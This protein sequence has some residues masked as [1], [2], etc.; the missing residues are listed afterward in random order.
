M[1]GVSRFIALNGPISI[2]GLL[3]AP[4][5]VKGYFE[6]PPLLPGITSIRDAPASKTDLFRHLTLI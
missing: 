4:P 6:V 3:G 2:A 1:I 5:G